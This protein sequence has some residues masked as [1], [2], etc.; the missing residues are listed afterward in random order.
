MINRNDL[1]QFDVRR[2]MKTGLGRRR[3]LRVRRG[4]MALALNVHVSSCPDHPWMK[5]LVVVEN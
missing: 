1:L 2:R 4:R 5:V 3:P